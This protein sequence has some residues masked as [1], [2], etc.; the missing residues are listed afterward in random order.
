MHVYSMCEGFRGF[1]FAFEH[2]HNM[3]CKDWQRSCNINAAALLI[4]VGNIY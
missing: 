3:V 4:L 2:K 1:G